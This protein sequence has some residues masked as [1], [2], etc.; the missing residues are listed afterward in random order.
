MHDNPVN[1]PLLNASELVDGI[2][3]YSA[4]DTEGKQN[5]FKL[6][7]K[8]KFSLIFKNIAEKLGFLKN[9]FKDYDCMTYLESHH[10]EQ[11]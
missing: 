1:T 7:V 3:I 8:L 9:I 10:T 2:E 11:K 4:Y 5:I 6:D